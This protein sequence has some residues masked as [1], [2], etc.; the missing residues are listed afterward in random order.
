VRRDMESV[1][2]TPHLW[3]RAI[4]GTTNYRKPQAPYVFTAEESADFT[5]RVSTT[6]TPMGF[7]ATLTKHIGEKRLVGLKSH[8]HHVLISNTFY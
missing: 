7:S 8:D 1:G 4:S 5:E 6:R 3:L 2:A